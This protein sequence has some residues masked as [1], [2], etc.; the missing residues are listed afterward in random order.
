VNKSVKKDVKKPSVKASG[1]S[2]VSKPTKR[3]KAPTGRVD[4]GAISRNPKLTRPSRNMQ[5]IYPGTLGV[6]SPV[7]LGGV[8]NP[9]TFTPRA[10]PPAP[11]SPGSQSP[12]PTFGTGPNPVTQTHVTGGF[13]PAGSDQSRIRPQVGPGL[14]MPTGFPPRPNAPR[15][16]TS[17][18]NQGRY[19]P[20]A[21]ARP[22]TGASGRFGPGSPMG[23]VGAPTY[24]PHQGSPMNLSP[25]Q[26]RLLMA[27][28]R[29]LGLL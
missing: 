6:R 18:V 9:F 16:Q 27:E 12:I 7:T 20:G 28:L 10:Q 13:A 21:N 15:P 17:K 3:K 24:S 23:G 26:E 5:P 25:A 2:S 11:A 22:T 4:R 19:A 29:K 8:R 1:A 14:P